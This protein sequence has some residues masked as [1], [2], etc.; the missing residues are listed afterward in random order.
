MGCNTSKET[1]DS[2]SK[3]KESEKNQSLN[4]ST[5]KKNPL[6]EQSSYHVVDYNVEYKNDINWND[7]RMYKTDNPQI[8]I[9]GNGGFGTIVKALWQFNPSTPNQV[10]EVAVKVVQ[11][12]SVE[13][14]ED[15]EKVLNDIQTR[16]DKIREADDKIVYKD[17]IIQAYGLCRGTLPL[18]ITQLFQ[19]KKD[20]P[21][22]GMVMRLE[23]GGSLVNLIHPT[24]EEDRI[25]KLE[26]NLTMKDKINLIFQIARAIAE[27]H[28]IR[29]VHGD[30]K[31]ANILFDS[32]WPPQI[33]L[34][35]FGFAKNMEVKLTASSLSGTKSR[36][37]T[38]TF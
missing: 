22:V 28:S 18:E 9:L 35:D 7:I 25:T 21:G 4:R 20:E 32:S 11:E 19:L 2:S 14:K 16:I 13:K 5:P 38:V 12:S 10:V 29:I 1:N 15:Y 26:R 8:M 36:T 17:C 37:G 33:R 6:L 24:I 30:I 27:L 3:Q 34:S 31:P 23:K